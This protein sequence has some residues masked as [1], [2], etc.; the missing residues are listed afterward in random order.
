MKYK[1][2]FFA[3]SRPIKNFKWVLDNCTVK[4]INEAQRQFLDSKKGMVLIDNLFDAKDE[5]EYLYIA[6]KI[7]QEMEELAS[8]DSC[9][10][11]C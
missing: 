2:D 7:E 9:L 6:G 11:Y 3:E 5:M 1:S 8:Q 10:S 4:I